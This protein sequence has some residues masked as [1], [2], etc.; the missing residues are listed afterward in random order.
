MAGMNFQTIVAGGVPNHM[1]IKLRKFLK[2]LDKRIELLDHVGC[3][4]AADELSY[5]RDELAKTIGEKLLNFQRT[6]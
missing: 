4:P 2:K 6:N 5:W 1:K 3:H